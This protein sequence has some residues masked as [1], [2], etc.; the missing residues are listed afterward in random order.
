MVLLEKHVFISLFSLFEGL[1]ISTM[2][3][4]FPSEYIPTVFD[5]YQEDRELNGKK[6][7]IGQ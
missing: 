5:N 2:T 1:L 3:K 6:F 4:E 7:T